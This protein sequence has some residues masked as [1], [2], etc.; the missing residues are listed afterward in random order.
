L[1]DQIFADGIGS[2]SV[3]GGTVRIDFVSFSPTESEVNGQP[4]AVPQHRLVMTIPAFLHS[5]QKIQEA[6]EAVGKIKMPGPA[7]SGK[8]EPGHINDRLDAQTVLSASTSVGQPPK[9]PFP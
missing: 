6:A 3:I 1:K 4:K 2:I 5:A 7:Q 9:P 8:P